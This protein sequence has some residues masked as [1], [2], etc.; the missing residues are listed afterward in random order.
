M[1]TVSVS[2][3]QGAGMARQHFS[4][5]AHHS[6]RLARLAALAVLV[7]GM[8]GCARRPAEIQAEIPDD[9]RERHAIVLGDVE[10]QLDVFLV[11]NTGLDRRQVEDVRKFVAGYRREGKGPLVATLPGGAP[12]SNVH[13]TLGEIRKLAASEGVKGGHLVI[14]RNGPTHPTAAAVRLHYAR[15][16]ARVVSKC[17]EWPHDLSGG[18][19]LQSWT[20][21]PYYNLGCSYQSHLAAQVADP[22]DL[23]RSRPEGEIDIGKRLGDIEAIRENEDPTTKWPQDQTRINQALQ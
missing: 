7:A 16:D 22:R 11:G 2:S 23:V 19:T 3:Q 8:A 1:A 4:G 17:G 21:R 20:N 5:A 6:R 18:P 14:G 15:L 9:Y 13:Q 10:R 12:G